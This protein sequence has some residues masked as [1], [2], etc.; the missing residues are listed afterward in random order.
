MPRVSSVTEQERIA[1]K[2]P[3]TSATVSGLMPDS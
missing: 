1:A 3:V 2:D